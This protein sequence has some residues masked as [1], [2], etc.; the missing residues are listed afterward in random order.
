MTLDDFDTSWKPFFLE[1][2]IK[3]FKHRITL[4]WVEMPLE[5]T[6]QPTEIAKEEVAQKL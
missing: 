3:T 4:R 5:S 2:L 6:S 1:I